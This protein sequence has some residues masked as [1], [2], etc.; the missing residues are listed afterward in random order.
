LS[1]SATEESVTPIPA[2]ICVVSFA[3][4]RG[5]SGWRRS[6]RCQSSDFLRAAIS[7]AG[8]SRAPAEACSGS[9]SP[10]LSSP[11]G[12]AWSPGLGLACLLAVTI[13]D[14][15]TCTAVQ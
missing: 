5:R 1:A 3:G 10:G 8:L 13:L 14:I 6:S 15:L 9:G 2:A 11:G 4:S 12:R 7:L